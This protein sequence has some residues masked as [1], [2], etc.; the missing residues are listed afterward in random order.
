MNSRTDVMINP[1][2][3]VTL[4]VVEP[5]EEHGYKRN[6]YQLELERDHITYLPTTW[7]LVYEITEESPLGKFSKE[8]LKELNGE[9]LI[10]VTYYD[11]AFNEE[12]YKLHSYTFEELLTDVTFEKAFYFDK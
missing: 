6:F 2:A 12:V 9:F 3:S 4:A 11:E 5:D 1:K 7:T 8:E 10:M